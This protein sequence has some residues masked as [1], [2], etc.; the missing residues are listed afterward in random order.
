MSRNSDI[1]LTS[2]DLKA[3]LE[4][5]TDTKPVDGR[6]FRINC[7]KCGN[8][9]F[10][11]YVNVEKLVWNCFRCNWGKGI[12]DISLLMAEVSNRNVNDVRKEISRF[13]IPSLKSEDFVE[14]LE[15]KLYK[16]QPKVKKITFKAMDMPGTD[17]EKALVYQQAMQYAVRRGLSPKE[18]GALSIRAA[19]VLRGN[20]GPFLIFPIAYD[21]K[22]V[23]YQG[24]RING[25][26]EP[27]YVSGPDIH[28]Y[29]FPMDQTQLEICRYTQY[30]VIV[31]GIFDAIAMWRCDRPA[32]CTF[33]K[34]ITDAQVNLLRQIGIKKVI[35]AW[36][37]DAQ[38]EIEDA[39]KRLQTTFDVYVAD[40]TKCIENTNTSKI[41]P[42]K[43]LVQDNM[44]NWLRMVI[45]TAF[46]VHDP[47]FFK[48]QLRR[49]LF[50]KGKHVK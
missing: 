44:R 43:V 27:K 49:A 12:R 28:D 20:P 46:S 22:I 32:V 19:G 4:R 41:D 9:K 50:Q 18:V 6:E 34:K 7:P 8:T 11:L 29:L 13:V 10:K 2:I 35:L 36:D 3:W 1:A 40:L 21:G 23:N 14:K 5:Y 25:D 24:R 30:V 47:E 33:G 38:K 39:A 16:K 17:N 45:D 37:P 15:E 48:W 26:F 42:G 31:E